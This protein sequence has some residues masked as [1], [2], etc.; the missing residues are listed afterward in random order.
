M[1]KPPK[2]SFIAR[3]VAAMPPVVAMN[4]RRLI[5]SFL[6]ARSASSLV[7]AS[8]RCCSWVCGIGSHSP[9]DT[10]CAGMGEGKGST[11]A[12]V[13]FAS[14]ASLSQ[15]SLLRSSSCDILS[16]PFLSLCGS[17]KGDRG[18]RCRRRTRRNGRG[19]ARAL[20]GS[21]TGDSR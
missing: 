16:T 11:S 18:R 15:V 13:H 4:F 6:A 8:M 14:C 10:T 19:A 12:L 2:T 20:G 1:K 5:P 3:K 17:K 9:F 7:R 21:R